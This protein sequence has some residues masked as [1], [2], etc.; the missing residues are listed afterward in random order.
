MLFDQG[1]DAKIKMQ[2]QQIKELERTVEQ[3]Q[4]RA[5]SILYCL[6]ETEAEGGEIKGYTVS[7]I[8]QLLAPMIG[9]RERHIFREEREVNISCA[10]LSRWFAQSRM[11]DAEITRKEMKLMNM[12]YEYLQGKLPKGVKCFA[13]KLSKKNAFSVIWFLQ[14]CI[15]C[16]PSKYECC[17]SCGEIYN[18]ESEGHHSELNGRSYCGSCWE[19]R[20]EVTLCWDCGDDIFTEKSWCDEHG[21]YL[22]KE[23][24]K[25]RY[26]KK[27]KKE[28]EV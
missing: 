21:E 26:R 5:D 11:I 18:S 14:E 4:E 8:K 3:M 15:D 20:A 12:L 23:C 7:H 17:S 24:K 27:A 16:L 25:E 2:E 9:S 22:C 19:N 10:G 1:K 28:E 13:P 6:E